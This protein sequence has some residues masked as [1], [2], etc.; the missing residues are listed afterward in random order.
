M[1]AMYVFQNLGRQLD[2]LVVA[3]IA[4]SLNSLPAANG[5]MSEKAAR[6]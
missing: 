1:A 4:N 6:V 5:S 3:L 2:V